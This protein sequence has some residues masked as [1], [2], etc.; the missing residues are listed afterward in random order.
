ME[1]M[2]NALSR[3]SS[4]RIEYVD[5]LRGFTMLLVVMCHFSVDLGYEG[6]SLNELFAEFRMPL[7]FF[8]SGFVLYKPDF[9]W[10]WN[11]TKAFIC[12]KF[13]PQLFWPTLFLLF[14]CYC[15]GVNFIPSF[16]S[17]SRFGYWF[18]YMLFEFYCLYILIHCIL[19]NI[20][21]RPALRDLFIVMFGFAI[22]A[23]SFYINHLMALSEKSNE[24]IIAIGMQQWFYFIYFVIGSRLRKYY[25]CYRKY[26]NKHDI[27]I[28]ICM[29][30]FLLFN[31]FYDILSEKSSLLVHL[32]TAFA[33]IALCFEFFRRNEHVFASNT[34]VGKIIQYV[35]RRTLDI[36]LIHYIVL[37]SG[38]R[39]PFKNIIKEY[40][41]FGELLLS[42]VVAAMVIVISL[43][44]SRVLRMSPIVEK[45]VFGVRKKV[46][47]RNTSRE[48]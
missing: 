24:I 35:G 18:T 44:I 6:Y 19:Q 17:Y 28:V 2:L 12:K 41:P 31:M 27:L 30:V 36:Y 7:F 11:N 13:W 22:M 10:T 25:E 37:Y 45:Y 8:V 5:A 33:G 47:H 26:M 23:F 46:N 38:F 4:H 1:R 21:I 20:A 15:Q 42:F 48:F 43:I 34:V 9:K 3:S 40:N 14:Y 39:M 29:C 32:I 16:V